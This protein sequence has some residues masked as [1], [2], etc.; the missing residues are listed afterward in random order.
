MANLHRGEIE[1]ELG[2][3]KRRLCLTLGALAQLEADL[4]TSDLQ[5]LAERFSSGRVSA[6]DLVSILHAG[7]VGGGH[8][9]DR[10]DV[11]S[12]HVDGG[13]AAYADIAARLL[14]VTFG[15][16]TNHD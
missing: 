6:R 8:T 12:M 10:D 13:L 14:T 9:L 3:A 7:L 15:T 5:G 11:E 2:G 16:P 4:Q 1:A